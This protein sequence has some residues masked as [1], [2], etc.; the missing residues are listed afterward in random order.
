MFNV[1][2]SDPEQK[3]SAPLEVEAKQ[4]C[5]G[6]GERAFAHLAL[7][8]QRMYMQQTRFP[9]F[10]RVRNTSI[11]SSSLCEYWNSALSVR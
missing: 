5:A 8:A 1:D 4:R 9:L 7:G 3:Q 2:T 10:D 11:M 6:L